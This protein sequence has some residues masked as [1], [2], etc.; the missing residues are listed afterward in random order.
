MVIRPFIF[1]LPS[2]TSEAIIPA[3]AAVALFSVLAFIFWIKQRKNYRTNLDLFLGKSAQIT[4]LL[5]DYLNKHDLHFYQ[6]K[7][8]GEIWKACSRE[9]L[10]TGMIV[11]VHQVD[12]EQL[13]LHISKTPYTLK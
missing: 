11:Y 12:H 10:E 5:E 6:I 3:L 4:S 13:L 7:I 8:N 1:Y 2:L 9:K